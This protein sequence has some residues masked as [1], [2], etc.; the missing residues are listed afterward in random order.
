MDAEAMRLVVTAAAIVGG[1]MVPAAAIA[2]IGGKGLEAI[3]RNPEAA[4]KIQTAM[5]LA[6]AF[7]EAIA[8]YALVIA[9]VVKFVV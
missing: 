6:I 7:A 4:S 5:V 1:T 9:L 2:W 3:G 8:I